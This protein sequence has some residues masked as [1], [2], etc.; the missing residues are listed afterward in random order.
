MYSCVQ[1]EHQPVDRISLE[2]CL[3]VLCV[4]VYSVYLHTGLTSEQ[5]RLEQCAIC[6][7]NV[8]YSSVYVCVCVVW[9]MAL[10]M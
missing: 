8:G 3:Y 1:F 5:C 6:V 9:V 10:C 2:L 7:C 4:F